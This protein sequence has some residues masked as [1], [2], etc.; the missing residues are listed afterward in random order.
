MPPKQDSASKYLS[1]L[2]MGK[3]LLVNYLEVLV[4][5][6]PQY[7]DLKVKDLIRFA[8]SKKLTYISFYL[9]ILIIN[10]QTENGSVIQLTLLYLKN[11]RYLLMKRQ[12][13]VIKS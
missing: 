9:N 8:G 2:M 12:I 13:I 6:V 4:I 11:S 5:K 7:G 10:S 3:K 1:D